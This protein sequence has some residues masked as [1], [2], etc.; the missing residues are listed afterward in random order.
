MSHTC[1]SGNSTVITLDEVKPSVITIGDGMKNK[2]PRVQTNCKCNNILNIM[3]FSDYTP[4]WRVIGVS[5]FIIN[6]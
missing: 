2:E 6:K 5:K 3:I 4:S 1:K